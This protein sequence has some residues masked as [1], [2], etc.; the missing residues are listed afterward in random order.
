MA[1]S[2]EFFSFAAAGCAERS[3][4]FL[5]APGRGKEKN[6]TANTYSMTTTT[7]EVY[8]SQDNSLGQGDKLLK[9]KKVRALNPGYMKTIN[10][11][12]TLPYGFSAKDQFLIATI[13]TTLD[14]NPVNN[15]AVEPVP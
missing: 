1:L 9:H 12:Y 8:L 14:S 3:W 6:Q 15:I 2:R 5:P 11:S 7:L 10:F 13:S 4:F